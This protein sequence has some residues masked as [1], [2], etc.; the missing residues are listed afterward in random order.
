MRNTQR[1]RINKI[2]NQINKIALKGR[3]NSLEYNKLIDELIKKGYYEHFEQ[4]LIT[5]YNIPLNKYK[6]V[7]E[8][9]RYTWNKILLE[10]RSLTSLKINSL[11]KNNNVYQ[12][13]QDF[14]SDDIDYISITYSGPYHSDT[15]QLVGTHSRVNFQKDI[16]DIIINL[17]NDKIYRVD[18]DKVIWATHSTSPIIEIPR[19]LN[20]VFGVNSGTWSYLQTLSYTTNIPISFDGNYM[21]TTWSRN[22][23]KKWI[24]K[25][26]IDKNNFLGTIKE[27]DSYVQ[28]PKYYQLNNEY[29]KIQGLRK[30]FLDVNKTG[31]SQSIVVI[32]DNP[33]ISEDTNLYNR[34]LIAIEYLLS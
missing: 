26:K 4:C 3:D 17:L 29:S 10:T 9:K 18:I 19:E 32:D 1:D 11:L 8:V 34:Y 14:Y 15:Y 25:V 13:G 23:F 24:Y 21:V 30:T 27:I 16:D 31:A 6:S 33:F 28:D 20:Q 22:P 2:Y 12:V 5:M 7:V